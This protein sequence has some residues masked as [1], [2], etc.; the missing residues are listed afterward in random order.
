MKTASRTL[1]K[2]PPEVWEQLD[3][4]GRMEGLMC[5]LVGHATGVQVYER[6]EES[7]LAWK[8]VPDEARIEVELAEKGWGTNVSVSAV[9]GQEPTSSRGGLTPSSTSS[10]P[11]RS[12]RSGACPRLQRRRSRP[13]PPCSRPRRRRTSRR[14]RPRPGTSRGRRRV[15]ESSASDRSG[16]FQR[17]TERLRPAL[18]F[19]RHRF[20]FGLLRMR[21]HL[22][23]LQAELALP[24]GNHLAAGTERSATPRLRI[25]FPMATRPKDEAQGKD[26]AQ[27]NGA[28][29]SAEQQAAV[30]EDLH[31]YI[32]PVVGPDDERVITDSGIE[33]K[34]LYEEDDVKPGLEERLGEP[35]SYPFTRGIHPG[36][37]RD[38]LWTMRQY[39]GYATAEE[40]NER[41]RYL[42][43]H[44][45]T[46]LSM[47]F[48][49]PTQLG[50]DSD[51]PLC[52]GEVGRT[53]VAI[54]TVE[55]MRIC[56]D[57]I[58]LGEVSTSMTINAPAAILLLLYELVG[59]EQ[60][61]P[62]EQL[63]GTVQ[64]DVL[65]EYVSRGNYIY[66]PEPTMRLTTDIFAY[67]DEKVPSWN[68]ISI[69]GYHMR[70]KGCSA[71]Q[72]VAFTLANAIAYV[73][74]GIEAG[75]DVDKFGKRLAFF[76]NGHNNV[77]QEIAKFRA[78]RRMWAKIMRERFDATDEK[79]QMIRFHTQTGGVTLQAQQPEVNIIRVALQGFA[80]VA[81]GTQSLHTNGFDEALA[82]PT[83]R[84]ARIA[85]RTQQ[86]LAHESGVADTVDPFA[87]SYFIESLTD[88]I[89]GRSWELMKKVEDL[90]GS[91]KALEFIQKEIEESAISYQERYRTGQDVIVGVNK[92]VTDVADD[93]DILKVD[94]EAEKRQLER[95]A[96]FKANRDQE[97]LDRKLEELREVARGDDNLLHPIK[98]ALRAGGSIGEVCNAMRDVFGEYRGGA[99]F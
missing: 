92:Y 77:F 2:S 68:T 45:S 7:K 59:E 5:A 19:C 95:L 65:K 23:L 97:E 21:L 52:A 98:E 85:L 16:A 15:A 94:P 81:G 54:D 9:S 67:C 10:P 93:V 8:A 62:A 53:G 50:R 29:E 58:D 79:A 70:E 31:R 37:Y 74:A 20:R 22:D 36:M 46:G 30:E 28:R 73:E 24:G 51:D 96:K 41:Y 82:L 43:E 63:R 17:L 75:L 55:D 86:V 56:F 27:T 99:F 78:V 14:L 72:E 26:G 57:Q 40:T 35:G 66:P 33:I 25:L 44:G 69:S 12:V 11:R 84:S 1:V 47:A 3:H 32:A 80:A 18:T 64:N 71:V 48:D 91:V 38:R 88:E 42:T 4:P 89:E 61:V 87:G 60:G 90:G 6:V 13:S 76:F 49:L 34:R 83:E 39:A